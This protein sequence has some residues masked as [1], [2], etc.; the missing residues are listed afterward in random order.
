MEDKV[1]ESRQNSTGTSIR[2]RRECLECRYRFT[3]YEQIEEK[4]LMVIKKDGSREPFDA[5]KLARGL[6]K[7]LE[8]RFIIAKLI[9]HNW[10]SYLK[11]ETLI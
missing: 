6:E 1:I 11:N 8:K 4:K 5:A 2:R 9:I 7:S 3:S 10:Y